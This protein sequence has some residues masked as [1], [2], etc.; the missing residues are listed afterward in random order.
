MLLP[1]FTIVLYT[2]FRMSDGRK[3]MESVDKAAERVFRVARDMSLRDWLVWGLV[4]LAAAF[5]WYL[6]GWRLFIELLFAS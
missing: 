3:I 4:I 2:G 5:L 1:D 6:Y